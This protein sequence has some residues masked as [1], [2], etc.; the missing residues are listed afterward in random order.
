MDILTEK[1]ARSYGRTTAV[2]GVDLAVER[3]ELYGLIGPDGAGKTTLIRMLVGLVRPDDGNAT[4][5]GFDVRRELFRVKEVIGYLSQRFSLYPD[6]SVRE[7]IRFYGDL[8]QV[9][10]SEIEARE[11]RLLEFSRLG[12]FVDRRA[13]ALSGGMKQKLALCCTLVHVPRILFLDEP[14]TGVD[15]LSRREF[16]DLLAELRDGGTTVF[17]S[18]AYME[19]AAR[20]NRV[21]L[22]YGG[23]V[24]AADT[25]ECLPE[26]YPYSMLEIVLPEAVS[27]VEQV[28]ALPGVK[29]VQ[30]FGDRLHVG[31]DEAET[32]VQTLVNAIA[33]RP[34]ARC[35]IRKIRPGLEDVFVEMI[36]G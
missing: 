34:E 35:S 16:W 3:G 14:T 11:K 31:I 2:A 26:L 20:C 1:L 22:M 17:V 19:E 21:S 5:G 9:E 6:L 28:E 15:P 27:R 36:R 10:K 30:V 23:R 12:P 24:L 32:D 13:G 7:N 18:T 33:C 8:F 4:V 25:P 29:S